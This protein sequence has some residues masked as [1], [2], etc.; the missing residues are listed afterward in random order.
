M[1]LVFP[2]NPKIKSK[3][4]RVN[5]EKEDTSKKEVSNI[6]ENMNSEVAEQDNE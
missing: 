3:I 1:N 5:K 2:T 4:S 6:E